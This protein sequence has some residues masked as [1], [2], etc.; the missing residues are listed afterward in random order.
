[1]PGHGPPSS[2]VRRAWGVG[3]PDVKRPGVPVNGQ[4]L[5]FP[6]HQL[7]LGVLRVQQPQ[8]VRHRLR[9]CD[10]E[11][12]VGAARGAVDPTLSHE[13]GRSPRTGLEG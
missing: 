10:G 5:R 4:V 2:K 7:P 11:P 3:T 6:G 12:V 9:V 8:L 13:R 1:M